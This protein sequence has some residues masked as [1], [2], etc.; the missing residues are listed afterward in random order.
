MFARP[1]QH[2]EEGTHDDA[3]GQEWMVNHGVLQRSMVRG[4]RYRRGGGMRGRGVQRSAAVR[5]N[6]AAPAT[7]PEQPMY[8]PPTR[9]PQRFSV[10]KCSP[11]GFCMTFHDVY[12]ELL[13][14]ISKFFRLV[15]N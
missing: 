7:R 13:L 8:R 14:I 2:P 3:N 5:K 6:I 9:G 12:R 4:A 11:G 1:L 15:R 10:S